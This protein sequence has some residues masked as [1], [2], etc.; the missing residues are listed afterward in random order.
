MEVQFT[1][2]KI[3][4]FKGHSWVASG[5]FMMLCHHLLPGLFGHPFKST[6]YPPSDHTQL[7]SPSW[8]PQTYSLLH[9]LVCSGPHRR[10]IAQ[11][12]ASR[13]QFIFTWNVCS[14][15]THGPEFPS[16]LWSRNGLWNGRGTSVPVRSA[17]GHLWCS[18]P[19]PRPLYAT[20]PPGRLHAGARAR[21]PCWALVARHSWGGLGDRSPLL[22]SWARV[23]TT[24][25]PCWILALE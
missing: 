5:G 1:E 12:V 7:P 25:P 19:T 10:G 24:V 3:N 4:Y 6:L 18:H 15:V 21:A 16:S 23:S 13:D 11:N 8:W 17:D 14:R 20:K 9:G 2:H 22:L